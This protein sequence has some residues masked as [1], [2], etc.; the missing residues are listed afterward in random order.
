M[1]RRAMFAIVGTL[2]IPPGDDG[3][4][5]EEMVEFLRTYYNFE[6]MPVAEP[7]VWVGEIWE[8]AGMTLFPDGHC[9]SRGK[10]RAS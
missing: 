1:S 8:S 3:Q 4:M 5:V 7:R 6:L 2:E 9:E 10:R